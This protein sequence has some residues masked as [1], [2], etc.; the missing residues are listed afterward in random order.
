MNRFIKAQSA[1]YRS[2]PAAPTARNYTEIC[3]RSNPCARCVRRRCERL[4]AAL[5]GLSLALLLAHLRF[6]ALDIV[7]L[8]LKIRLHARD[9]VEQLRVLRLERLKPRLRRL[10]LRVG[11]GA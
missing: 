4:F 1:L 5:L 11:A 7:V 3:V 10:Q 8:S 9:L 2:D 6:E